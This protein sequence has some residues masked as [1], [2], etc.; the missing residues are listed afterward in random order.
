MP[1]TGGL[2][3]L[4]DVRADALCSKGNESQVPHV[5]AEAGCANTYVLSDERRW[6]EA[7]DLL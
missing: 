5:L 4:E 7:R 1:L 6:C 2:E 3:K